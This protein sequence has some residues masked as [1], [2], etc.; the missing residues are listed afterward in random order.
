MNAFRL[1][2][3][4]AVALVFAFGARAEE[5]GDL[6]K[7]LVGKWEITKAEEGT[8]PVGAMVTFT[9]DGKCTVAVKVG[10]KEE[11]MEGKYKTEPHKFIVTFKQGDQEKTHTITVTKITDKEMT[12]KDE[13]GKV[14]E[15]KKKS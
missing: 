4:G 1:L 2:A 9:K 14:V 7:M 12:T 15:C 3:V 8:V 10:D 6:A 5:K 13:D 11:T